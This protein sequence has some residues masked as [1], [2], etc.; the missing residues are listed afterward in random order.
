MSIK[1]YAH[2][3]RKEPPPMPLSEFRGVIELNTA[4]SRGDKK[5]AASVLARNFECES[6]DIRVLEWSRLQ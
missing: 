1:Y 3:L 6:N 4:L 2:F 5:S